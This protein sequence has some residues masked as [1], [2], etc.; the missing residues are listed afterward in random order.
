MSKRLRSPIIWVGGKGNMAAKLLKLMPE[1]KIYV[2]PFGG[3]ASLLFAKEPSSVEVYN[4]LDERL[5]DLF[6]VLS[7]PKMF[8]KFYRRVALLPHSRQMFNRYH[9]IW[10][11]INDRVERAA[12]WYYVI[13]HTFGGFYAP[14]KKCWAYSINCSSRGMSALTSKWLS[15]LEMLPEIHER[16]QRVQIEHNDFQKIFEVYDTPDTLF[17]ADPPYVLSTRKDVRYKCD[18]TNKEHRKLIHILLNLKGK[19]MLSGY[20]CDLYK[21]L[22]KRSWRLVRFPTKKYAGKATLGKPK[23]ECVECVWMNY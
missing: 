14:N 17:Y 21:L 19:V 7:N 9:D 20:E 10:D 3:G 6:I 16:L 8:E 12:R 13:R 22:V 11:K 23:S 4:D 1:H 5:Y 15:T 18:M 2:E